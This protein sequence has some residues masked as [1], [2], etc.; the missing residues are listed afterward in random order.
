MTATKYPS[1]FMVLGVHGTPIPITYLQ[2]DN[3]K[4]NP[5]VTYDFDLAVELAT[6]GQID[7]DCPHEIVILSTLMEGF[8][9][10]L[11]DTPAFDYVPRH[12]MAI[13]NAIQNAEEVGRAVECMSDK[14]AELQRI[15]DAI[16]V[17]VSY[18]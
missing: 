10:E 11:S 12:I 4:D 8:D 17:V 9:P 13:E 3:E 7:T 18:S 1:R 6:K 15:K 16:N 14:E 2:P 5:Y